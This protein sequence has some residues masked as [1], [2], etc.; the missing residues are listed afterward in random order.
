MYDYSIFSLQIKGVD[1]PVLALLVY[2]ALYALVLQKSSSSV[3]PDTENSRASPAVSALFGCYFVVIVTVTLS[4]HPL[5]V[6][7]CRPCIELAV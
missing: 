5:G 4:R 3:L 7:I 2:C 1:L 6:R